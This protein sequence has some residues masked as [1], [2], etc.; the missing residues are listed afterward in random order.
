MS[1]PAEKKI[2]EGENLKNRLENTK[3]G[4]KKYKE[5]EKELNAFMKRTFKTEG[6]KVVAF[7]KK[8]NGEYILILARK[9]KGKPPQTIFGEVSS[10]IKPSAF[11][12]KFKT[13][14]NETVKPEPKKTDKPMPKKKIKIKIEK[15]EEPKKKIK[16]KI[17]IEKPEEPPK[18][19]IRK[20][21]IDPQEEKPKKL[22]EPP[23][24]EKLKEPPKP[25]KPAKNEL[26]FKSFENLKRLIK[27]D[28]PNLMDSSVN[29][30]MKHIKYI[31][32]Q[33]TRNF[34]ILSNPNAVKIRMAKQP[35]LRQR[36]IINAIV[37]AVK[38]MTKDY[39]FL[40]EYEN[41]RDNVNLLYFKSNPKK[42]KNEIKFWEERKKKR[43]VKKDFCNPS[44]L[45]APVVNKP[46]SLKQW[47][48]EREFKGKTQAEI[49]EDI[50]EYNM[51]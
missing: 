38:S 42:Y 22:K 25:K 34:N 37:V 23:K 6:S 12:V 20:I 29:Q 24:P 31:L 45:K 32:E 4:S 13:E 10:L 48:K 2:K 7:A 49:Q 40:A 26:N 5:L 19:V 9:F 41:C 21:K 27:L 46:K 1:T 28:R 11:N 44:N 18:K 3:K 8:T 43:K 36:D 15:P 50:D 33:D 30:Y 39:H 51:I 47:L 14:K 17:K 16:I 35:P